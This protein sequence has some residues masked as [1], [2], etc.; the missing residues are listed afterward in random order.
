MTTSSSF[1]PR[2]QAKRDAAEIARQEKMAEHNEKQAAAAKKAK[3]D[4]LKA[5]KIA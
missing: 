5:A 4:A 2:R 1:R 3:A